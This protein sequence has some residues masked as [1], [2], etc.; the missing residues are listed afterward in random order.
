MDTNTAGTFHNV[1]L[2]KRNDK[3]KQKVAGYLLTTQTSMVSC[4]FVAEVPPRMSRDLKNL[5]Q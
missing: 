5:R 4:D 1:K 3:S 2:V